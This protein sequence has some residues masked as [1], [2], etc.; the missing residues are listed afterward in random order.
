MKAFNNVGGCFPYS[1]F[2]ETRVTI[3]AAV[4]YIPLFFM[5]NFISALDLQFLVCNKFLTKLA[6]LTRNTVILKMY[7]FGNIH[8]GTPT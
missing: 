1:Y 8:L 5:G 3:R 6:Y 4:L 2:C 7:V